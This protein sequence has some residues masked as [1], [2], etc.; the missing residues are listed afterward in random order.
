MFNMKQIERLKQE[1]D[2][3]KG[4]VKRLKYQHTINENLKENTKKQD[5]ERLKE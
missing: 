3:F 1:V 4:E 5:S 2:N